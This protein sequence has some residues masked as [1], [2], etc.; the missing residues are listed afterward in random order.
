M[1]RILFA[2]LGLTA[3][4]V[5]G[6]FTECQKSCGIK[7]GQ[8]M[9]TTFDVKSCMKEAASCAIGC[10]SELKVEKHV[11]KKVESLS[12]K[13]RKNLGECQKQCGIKYAQCL[14]SSFDL[15]GCTTQQAACALGCFMGEKTHHHHT[16]AVQLDVKNEF[17]VCQKNC[18]IE[19]GQCLVTTFDLK[20]CSQK[21]ASCAIGCLGK[22]NVEKKHFDLSVKND[23]SVCQK[24]CGITYAQCLITKFDF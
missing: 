19:Y 6:S 12:V 15:K 23:F 5:Y 18:A 13:A 9:V 3:S 24:N 7:L 2:V 10:L 8:C 17:S 20:G 21:E 11:Q 14:V 16:A 1:K 22:L 4:T